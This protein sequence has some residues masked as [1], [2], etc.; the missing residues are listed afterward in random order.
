[1]TLF[2]EDGFLVRASL[3][4]CFSECLQ[5]GQP[6]HCFPSMAFGVASGVLHFRFL[7]YWVSYAYHFSSV[8]MVLSCFSENLAFAISKDHFNYVNSGGCIKSYLT[9][10]KQKLCTTNGSQA[11]HLFA[12]YPFSQLLCVNFHALLC[13]VE[14]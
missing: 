12:Y 4:T 9:Y 10:L 1:M 5:Q 6:S 8:F 11:K 2:N 7:D 3:F 14:L 13:P